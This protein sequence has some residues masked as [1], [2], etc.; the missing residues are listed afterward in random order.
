MFVHTPLL[1]N[2]D[3]TK[4]SK[5]KNPVWVSWY[6]QQGFL[7]E[8]ILNYLGL[9]GYS[10]ADGREIF[11]LQEFI[12][13]FDL[14]KI[15]TTAP[16]FNLE[17]LEWLNGEYI[18]KLDVRSLKSKII[19][20]IG[21]GYNEQLVEKTVPLIQTRIKKFAD[22]LPLCEF[23]FQPPTKYELELEPFQ[24]WFR[25][26]VNRYTKLKVWQHQALYEETKRLTKQFSVQR[27]KL[28]MSLR[29]AITGKQVGPPL[30]ESMEILGQRECIQRLK[31]AS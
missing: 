30:F 16:I 27:K 20:Y 9:L 8:A 14:A 21:Q 4:L 24:E 1:R 11:S 7:P 18:R 5:R 28:F 22:Y 17:K 10:M 26:L 15:T 6:K 23:F 2:P 25:A 29:V 3:K 13:E 31:A 12:Q 19:E